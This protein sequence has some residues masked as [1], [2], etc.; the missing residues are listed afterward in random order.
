SWS[1]VLL[2]TAVAEGEICVLEGD[3]SVAFAPPDRHVLHLEGGGTIQV[4]RCTRIRGPGPVV[5][6]A[7]LDLDV[8]P[9][10]VAPLA[11]LEPDP[12]PGNERVLRNEAHRSRALARD[13][14][15]AASTDMYGDARRERQ[16][17]P[18]FDG[19]QAV[20][21]G[22]VLVDQIAAPGLQGR[23]ADELVIAQL[24]LDAR[25]RRAS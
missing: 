2:E 7:L 4:E 12:L 11:I 18:F 14:Q 17:N 8:L 9:H 10:V 6:S 22:Q 23:S 16:G 25:A 13:P 3:E 1:V 15:G 24:R 5:A 20:V 21:E 19:D